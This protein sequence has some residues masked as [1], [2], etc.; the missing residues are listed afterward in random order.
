MYVET[1]IDCVLYFVT[2]TDDDR[3]RHLVLK[4]TFD[5][6]SRVEIVVKKDSDNLIKVSTF[7]CSEFLFS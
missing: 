6:T 2:V 3:V 7:Q 1:R 4:K 5:I